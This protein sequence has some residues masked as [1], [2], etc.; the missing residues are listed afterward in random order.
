MCSVLAS[1][2]HQHIQEIPKTKILLVLLLLLFLLYVHYSIQF[3][4]IQASET[5][6]TQQVNTVTINSGAPTISWGCTMTMNGR[7]ILFYSISQWLILFIR[8]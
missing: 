1:L 7:S 8:T 5:L 3:N 4:S 2:W 6:K